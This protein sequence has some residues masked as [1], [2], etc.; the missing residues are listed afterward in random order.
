MKIAI[1]GK[2][3]RVGR[4]FPADTIS[5]VTRLEADSSAMVAE[6]KSHTQIDCVI[7]LAAIM[8]VA[9]CEKNP[10]KAHDVNVDGALKWFKAAAQAGVKRFI[11][12]STSHV[13]GNPQ[14]REPVP[15][16]WPLNPV[17]VYGKT[18]AE[19][20]NKLHELARQYP[21]TK[22]TIVRMFSLLSKDSNPAQ[23]YSNL[24]RRARE[25]DFS[26]VPGLYN[27]RDFLPVEIA[28]L[29]LQQLALWKDAPEVVHICSGKERNVLDL[30]TEVF[31]EFGLDAQ[32]LL[33]EGEKGS[34]DIPYLV[35]IPTP[36][37]N[38]T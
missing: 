6:L 3:G 14:V 31:A 20:E 30:A 27:V 8:V 13:Y 16:A 17:S 22:L 25:K 37:P 35:G 29:R 19:A 28:A 7:H 36:F 12:T 23:L 10:Q 18:K 34:A 11:F 5:L 15:T 24:Y 4:Q 1:T 9:D 2:S 33:R 32:A 26:P 21:E 38:L